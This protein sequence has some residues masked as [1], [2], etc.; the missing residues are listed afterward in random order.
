MIEAAVCFI[1]IILGCMALI[2]TLGVIYMFISFFTM[3][4]E[5]FINEDWEEEEE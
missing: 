4:I 5:I 3:I 1:T 2:C